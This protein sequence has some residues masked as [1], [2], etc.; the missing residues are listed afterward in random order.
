MER[1]AGCP[2]ARLNRPGLD[3]IAAFTAAAVIGICR[4]RAPTALKTALPIAGP[5][6]VVAGSPSPT[7]ASVLSTKVMSSSGTSDRRSGV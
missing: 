7:G 1:A 4:R 2:A 6:T 5:T 3:Q